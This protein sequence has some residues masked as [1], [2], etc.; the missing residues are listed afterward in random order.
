MKNH[1]LSNIPAPYIYVDA[2]SL[3]SSG[4]FFT[5]AQPRLQHKKKIEDLMRVVNIGMFLEDF[6]GISERVINKSPFIYT[7]FIHGNIPWLVK[8]LRAEKTVILV[9]PE[10]MFKFSPSTAVRDINF[11][12]DSILAEIHQ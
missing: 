6:G 8:R 12:V 9:E 7:S 10:R 2:G 11:S 1:N 4:G 5:K 3:F